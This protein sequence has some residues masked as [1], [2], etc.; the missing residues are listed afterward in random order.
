MFDTY[1]RSQEHWSHQEVGHSTRGI[2]SLL[3]DQRYIHCSHYTSIYLDS[4][5]SPIS[6]SLIIS[7]VSIANTTNRLPPHIQLE[8]RERRFC[9]NWSIRTFVAQCHISPP[10]APATLSAS[11]TIRL[12]R[13]GHTRPKPKIGCSWSSR[14]GSLWWKTTSARSWNAYG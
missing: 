13:C 11:T 14:I 9:L 2:S 12:A 4:A 7:F 3:E 10:V 6:H 8:N 1:L 5:T